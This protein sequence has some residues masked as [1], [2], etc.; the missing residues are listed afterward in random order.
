VQ[1]KC[2]SHHGLPKKFLREYFEISQ[3]GQIL[4]EKVTKPANY[5][6]NF[7]VKFEMMVQDTGFG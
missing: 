6:W 7:A 1:Q 5:L 3:I 4:K 2:R